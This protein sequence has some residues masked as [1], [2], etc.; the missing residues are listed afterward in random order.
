MQGRFHVSEPVTAVYEWITG[1]LRDPT[2]TYELIKPDRRQLL[3]A[4]TVGDAELAPAVLL[5]FWPLAGQQQLY[6]GNQYQ[7]SCLQDMLI[8]EAQAV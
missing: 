3:G 8:A 1:A 2:M 6:D 7:A 5:S 4:G